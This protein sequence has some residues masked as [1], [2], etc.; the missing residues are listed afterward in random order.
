MKRAMAT[1]YRCS[2]EPA[3]TAGPAVPKPTYRMAR[4]FTSI[5]GAGDDVARVNTCERYP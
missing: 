1:S 5:I 4:D 2:I 3:V